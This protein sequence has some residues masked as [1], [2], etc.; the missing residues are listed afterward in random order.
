MGD[1]KPSHGGFGEHCILHWSVLTSTLKRD[2]QS[3]PA[4]SIVVTIRQ[5]VEAEP[6]LSN[7][8]SFATCDFY[9]RHRMKFVFREDE[10][11]FH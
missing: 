11:K 4:L 5:D 6:H 10:G 9:N 1:E 7:N 8:Q 3:S 2:I